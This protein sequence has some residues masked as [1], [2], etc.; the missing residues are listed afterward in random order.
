MSAQRIVV[1]VDDSQGARAA[2]RWARDEAV[3]RSARLEVVTVWV[4]PWAHGFNAQ[5]EQD[6]QWF[7]TQ[8]AELVDKLIAELDH[9]PESVHPR[10]VEVTA[11]GPAFGLLSAA[12]GADLLVVGARGRGGFASLLV[13]SVAAQVVHHAPCPV[14]VV[15]RPSS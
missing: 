11:D 6:R 14:V 7:E 1:G 4:P 10:G 2:L 12:E 15:P 5:W 3:L 8:A 9:V 13:G